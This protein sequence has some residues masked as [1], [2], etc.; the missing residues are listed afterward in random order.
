MG[1]TTL[2]GLQVGPDGTRPGEGRKPVTPQNAAGLRREL[3][4]EKGDKGLKRVDELEADAKYQPLVA[5]AKQAE[6]KEE[7]SE[8]SRHAVDSRVGASSP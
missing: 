8:Q 7:G 6:E 4:T 1:P 2:N 5:Q 3:E